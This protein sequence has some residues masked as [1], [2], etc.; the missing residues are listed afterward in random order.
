MDANKNVQFKR[1]PGFYVVL[2]AAVM[3]LVSAIVYSVN[4][5]GVSY[6][7]GSLFSDPVFIGLIVAAV[8]AVVLLFV[9]LEGFAPV[10]LCLASGIAC[11]VYI[12]RMVWPIADI[13][14]AIDPVAFVPEL[15]TCGALLL[16]SFVLA[17]VSLY[18]KKRVAL[19]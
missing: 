1:A 11:L 9:K 14:T 7:H 13:F 12:H 6:S 2:A 16:G 5:R 4:F 3:C 19:G 18:M 17:E 8:A 10:V 15:I